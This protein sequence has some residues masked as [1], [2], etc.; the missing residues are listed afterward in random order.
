MYVEGVSTRKV[1]AMT[2]ALCRLRT[3]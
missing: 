3:F 2:E 1:S